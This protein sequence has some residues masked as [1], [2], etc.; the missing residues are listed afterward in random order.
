MSISS[1]TRKAGPFSC[2]GATVSFPFA[3][4]VFTSA[5][6]RAVLTDPGG[7]ESDLV[8]GTHYTVS[9]NPDQDS[10]PGGSVV[11]TAT[12]PAGYLVTLT[13]KLQNLQPVTLTN[14][15]GF[16]P[17]VLNDAF[18]RATI[19]IQQLSEQ[20]SRAVKVSISSSIT[21]DQLVDSINTSASNAA[22]AASAAA[23]KLTEFKGVYYGPYSSDPATDPNG[24]APNAGDTYYNTATKLLMVFDG[25]TWVAAHLS[26]GRLVNIVRITTPGTGTYTKPAN[27][28]RLLIY[29][30]GGG[31]GGTDTDLTH[32]GGGGGAGG[33][34]EKFITT[35]ATSYAY[36]VGAGGV[37]APSGGVGGSGMPTT[38]EG[39]IAY[40][41]SS[42]TKPNGGTGGGASGGDFSV[43]G[44]GG[45]TGSVYSGGYPVGGN[46]G[47]SVFGGG[48]SGGYSIGQ[49]GS[50]FGSGGGGGGWNG[51]GPLGG[52]NGAPGYIEIWEFE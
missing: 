43:P 5:D 20:V 51:S 8:L 16:Y 15:G 31:G 33:Y 12:Y 22:A 7:V 46:G 11:T 32:G 44:G 40:G 34:A 26:P 39:I 49:P 47:A 50:A 18:D 14:N 48:G 45:G 1:T 9:L 6:V 25:S 4:K 10:N 41:G 36:T 52:G 30:I 37:G 27:V 24:N 23:A 38:I 29:A 2:N 17:A 28:N 35:P 42:G 19:Q 3:F 13:S 21:P